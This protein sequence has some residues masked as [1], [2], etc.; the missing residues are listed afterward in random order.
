MV[1][2]DAIVAD[3]KVKKAMDLV[4]EK[5]VITDKAPEAVVAGAREQAA[6]LQE[7][8]NLLAQSMDALK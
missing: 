4:R 1:A 6:A 5:A 8:L 7:K 3:M 2:A